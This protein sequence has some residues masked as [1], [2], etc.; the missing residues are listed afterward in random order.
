MG[1]NTNFGV[2]TYKAETNL[3]NCLSKVFYQVK[4]KETL[5]E[6]IRTKTKLKL[7]E[8]IEMNKLENVNLKQGQLLQIGWVVR[9]SKK[10]AGNPK[11]K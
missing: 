4:A 10:E 9:C 2:L 8:L 3:P 5:Y 7:L 1:E 6:I 11:S